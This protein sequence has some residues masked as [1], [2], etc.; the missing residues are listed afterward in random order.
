MFG[1]NVC[2]DPHAQPS[3]GGAACAAVMSGGFGHEYPASASRVATR[4]ARLACWSALTLVVGSWAA[5]N[6]VTNGDFQSGDL[7][8]WTAFVTTNGTIGTPDVI[9]FRYDRQ[10]H[11]ERRTVQRRAGRVP[12]WSARR[13]WYLSER[14][15]RGGHIPHVCRHCGRGS[16]A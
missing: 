10:R 14:D 15:H 6:L 2:G 9:S 7:S 3:K 16:A 8:G 5:T 4:P 12:I 13:R 11:V 1:Q